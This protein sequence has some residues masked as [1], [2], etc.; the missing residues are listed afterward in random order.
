MRNLSVALCV[1]FS[2]MI[3]QL[4]REKSTRDNIVETARSLFFEQG[5]NATGIAQILAKS[6]AHSG[7]LYH[8]FPAKEDLLLAVLSQYKEMLLPMVIDPARERVAE[9]IDRI[10][11]VLHGYRLLLEAT[12]F[13]LGCP[14]G[15]LALEVSN[16]HP[17][18]RALIKENFDGW[19]LEVE[20]LIEEARGYLP[21]NVDSARLAM[22]LL[23]MMEGAVMLARTYRSLEPFDQA[24]IGL[25]ELFD[26]LVIK[27]TDWSAPRT[28]E[29]TT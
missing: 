3:D 8:F 13:R 10:F 27:G 11:S 19:L 18:P 4:T 24:V 25:R 2:G 1:L 26:E 6:G 14:I 20:K 16:S 28:Q 15:N 9:P 21:A 12:D 29:Q 22:L 7:S 17:N 5:Y 23:A